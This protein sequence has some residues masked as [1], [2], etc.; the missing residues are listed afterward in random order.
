[1]INDE[2]IDLNDYKIKIYKGTNT[3]NPDPTI[4]AKEGENIS[5]WSKSMRTTF[6][7]V[8]LLFLSGCVSTHMKQY[9]GM[10]IREVILDSGPPLNAM[11]MGGGV[12]AFQ[13]RWGGGS[14]PSITTTDGTIT[15]YGNSAWLS[16]TSITIGG[17]ISEGCL[18][19]YMT[20]WNSVR[21]TWVV[22]DI[23]YPKRLLC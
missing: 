9:I 17:G 2:L 19:S 3:Q 14:I 12:R 22:T 16:S 7:V 6:I 1:M 15:S 23:R 13:F 11:D 20:T 4:S 21:Q 10:D 5:A 18:I 8:L